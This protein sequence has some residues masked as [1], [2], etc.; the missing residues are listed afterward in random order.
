MDPMLFA[1]IL[2]RLADGTSLLAA[3]LAFAALFGLIELLD[4]L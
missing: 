3:A 2:D 4:R 1:S